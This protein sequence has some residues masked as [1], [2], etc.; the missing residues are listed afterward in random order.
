MEIAGAAEAEE[1]AEAAEED[2]LATLGE[3]IPSRSG[4]FGRKRET[5]PKL[6]NCSRDCR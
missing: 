2:M 6:K 5:D 1:V 4:T 3:E